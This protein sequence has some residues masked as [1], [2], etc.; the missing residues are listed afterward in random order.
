MSVTF[1][2]DPVT[3][4]QQ[5][6][7]A[8]ISPGA[9]I[10]K[11][12]DIE[13]EACGT[14][15]LDKSNLLGPD[16]V[17]GIPI[18]NGFMRAV[19]AAY[20][21]HFP[22]ILS[23][24]DVWLTIAQGFAAHVNAYAGLLRH[25]FVRHEGQEVISVRRDVFIKGNPDN[26]WPGVFDEF[27][28]KIGQHIGE[29]KRDLLVSRFSLTGPV[30]KAV[31]EVVLMDAMKAYFDYRVYTMCGIPE[32]TLLGTLDDW[33][34]IRERTRSLAE[35]D[36]TEWTDQLGKAID[37]FTSAFAGNA[38]PEFWG[39]FYK[40]SGGSG[41]P[42]ISGKINVFFPYL[43]NHRSGVFDL[44]NQA[45]YE[46]HSYAAP[47]DFPMG[48]SKAPFL[49]VYHEKEFPMEFL[50]GFIGA[51]QDPATL[52]VRPALGWGVTDRIDPNRRSKTE[53]MSYS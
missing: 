47:A 7:F 9:S 10:Q 23:P 36:C 21:E 19:H 31:S 32:V 46:R 53:D 35:F 48:L 44:P 39:D 27:S 43:K 3:R 15:I 17:T 5:S 30:E 1:A 33:Q 16:A 2:V 8:R 20:S 4:A 14:N 34:S 42:F 11:L 41:G 13:V 49:W 50:G 37:H 45:I 12:I 25:K 51:A 26:D 38:D 18:M 24:D 22:L 29:D 40:Q 52:E 6:R 28:T